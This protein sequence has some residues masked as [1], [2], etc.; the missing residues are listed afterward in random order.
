VKPL[1]QTQGS[2]DENATELTHAQLLTNSDCHQRELL[3]W[4]L[5]FE[6]EPGHRRVLV[7][8]YTGFV[9]QACLCVQLLEAL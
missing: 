3:A 5:S 4:Q 2:E 7:L 9:V 1:L 6:L 8:L